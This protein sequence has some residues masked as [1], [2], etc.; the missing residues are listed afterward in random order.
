MACVH[1]S[2]IIYVH[3]NEQGVY[4]VRIHTPLGP[5]VVVKKIYPSRSGNNSFKQKRNI[6]ARTATWFFMFSIPL[7]YLL[8]YIYIYM[9]KRGNRPLATFQIVGAPKQG[10]CATAYDCVSSESV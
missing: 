2:D 5:L 6:S 8:I 10:V 4:V 9:D 1:C 7:V 3:T